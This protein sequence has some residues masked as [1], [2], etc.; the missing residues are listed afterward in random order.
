V[1]TERT[2]LRARPADL[3]R[4]DTF[5]G[6]SVVIGYWGERWRWGHIVAEVSVLDATGRHQL[7]EVDPNATWEVSR[8]CLR[9]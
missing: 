5:G 1:G 2:T 7:L 6:G 3:Q 4:G 8:R 9:R